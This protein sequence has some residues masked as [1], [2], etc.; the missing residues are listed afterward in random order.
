MPGVFFWSMAAMFKVRDW[1]RPRGQILDAVPLRLGHRV[2]D[3][4]CGP[5][6]Y[7]PELAMRVGAAGQV[8][9]LDI[10]PLAIRRVEVLARRRGL[11]QVVARRTDGIHVPGVE[12]RSVDVV[13][14][15]DVFHMLSDQAAVLRECRRVLRDDGVLVVGDPHMDPQALVSGVSTLGGFALAHQ[16]DDVALFAPN[17]GGTEAGGVR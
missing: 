3:Y 5:G 6:A 16:D 2:V 7:V 8:I 1:I 11:G 4:G 17:S 9:A 14:L 13:L 10:H 15:L 12:D